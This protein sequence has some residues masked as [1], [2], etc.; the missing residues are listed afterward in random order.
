[1]ACGSYEYSPRGRQGIGVVQ[2]Q[3]GLDYPF[4]APSPDIEYL[5][6]DLYLAYEISSPAI[7]HPLRLKWIYG[8]GCATVPKPATAPT[9]THAADLLIVDANDVPVFNST[10]SGTSF[11]TWCWGLNK[12]AACPATHDYKIYEWANSRG[13]C[14]VVAYQTWPPSAAGD[15]ETTVRQFATHIEPESATLDERSV[16]RMPKRVT[17][18][19]LPNFSNNAD[20][21]LTNTAIDIGAG[22]N[23]ALVVSDAQTRGLR[24]TRQ[25]TMSAVAGEG[26]GKYVDCAETTPVIRN[27][28]G[29]SGPNLLITAKD[30]LWSYVPTTY[31]ASNNKLVPQRVGGKATQK[32]GSNCP[33]CC[34]CDDYVDIATYMNSTRNR[35]KAIGVATNGVLLMHSDN[36]TRWENQRLCRL[37][38]PLKVCMS[39]QRCPY[40]DIVA[41]YCNNCTDCA[42]D[43]VMRIEFDAS[44]ANSAT[45][46][47]GYTKVTTAQATQ[48]LYELDGA[49]P[50][51]TAKLG[52]VD[53]GNSATVGFR[54]LFE[55]ARATN[56]GVAVTATTDAGP[57][58][59]GCENTSAVAEATT[60][61][62]LYCDD[63]GQTIALC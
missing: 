60:A 29:L 54:L 53:V 27:L 30:C 22:L 43:V 50:V 8:V 15:D 34:T 44:P 48:D 6:A 19:V 35:Y 20:V 38:K 21:R 11:S 18:L 14:R 13:V 1:M 40:L 2:P 63:A 51:F 5:L 25:I 24:A 33:A 41:Q 10:T 49:W 28:N 26:L 23:N 61:K 58:R 4:I 31:K 9:P 37:Q 16:Y 62:A 55:N 17:A 56:V 57:V 32:I 36:I 45:T 52:N 47:C 39:A 3:S 12:T 46:V 59:F 7:T 42:N